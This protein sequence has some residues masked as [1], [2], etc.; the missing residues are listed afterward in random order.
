MSHEQV[1][2]IAVHG[3]AGDHPASSDV[4]VKRTLRSYDFH[5][6]DGNYANLTCLPLTN[7]QLA[8]HVGQHC[9]PSR[10]GHQH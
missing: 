9:L 1:Y 6:I 2:L 8:G 4:E 10:K 7:S 5:D 3:G